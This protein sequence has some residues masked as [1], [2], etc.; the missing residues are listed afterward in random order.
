M[1]NSL[2]FD[3]EAF[4]SKSDD[5]L[6]TLTSRRLRYNSSTLGKAHIIS[7][8]LEK[9]ASIEIHY[10][11]WYLILITGILGLGFELAMSTENQDDAA[12]FG[13]ALGAICIVVFFV[14]RKHVITVA[15]DGGARINFYTRGMSRENLLH[16]INKIEQAKANR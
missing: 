10:R 8:A 5:G 1:D 13:F 9:I 2:L 14:T 11:S 15:S 6:I 4:L 16:F 3:N 7:I 12:F